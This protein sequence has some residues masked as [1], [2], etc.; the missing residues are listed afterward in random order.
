MNIDLVHSLIKDVPDFPK[1][2][3]LFKDITPVLQN[4]EAF[5]QLTDALGELVPPE[6]EKLVAIESRG[7]I[8]GSAVAQKRNIAMILARKPG[9]LPRE[10]YS[11]TYALE[12]GTDEL[13]IHKDALEPSDKV[14]IIDDVL[15]TGGTA[16]AAEDL[17]VQAGAK[18]LGSVF[19]MEIEVLK[20]RKKLKH[21]VSSLM[22]V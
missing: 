6:T 10:V 17:C 15:A 5:H 11:K 2:G 7:F 16:H 20:G 9:K 8:L 3:V 14:C 21:N 12:Y 4:S 19:I 13:Q 22:L 18:V 1:P